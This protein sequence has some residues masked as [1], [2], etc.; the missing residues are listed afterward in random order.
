MAWQRRRGE[1]RSASVFN[2]APGWQSAELPSDEEEAEP[3]Q[4]DAQLEPEPPAEVTIIYRVTQIFGRNASE[5]TDFTSEDSA[6]QHYQEVGKP[7]FS[8]IKIDKI[9]NPDGSDEEDDMLTDDEFCPDDWVCSQCGSA[10]HGFALDDPEL[11]RRCL[12]G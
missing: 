2:R 6:R 8:Y 3:E 1:N 12:H 7:D 11:C 4:Q 10:E 9:T 5:T